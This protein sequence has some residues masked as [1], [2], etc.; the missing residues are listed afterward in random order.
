MAAGTAAS[1]QARPRGAPRY[2]PPG[3]AGWLPPILLGLLALWLTV[4]L[5]KNPQQFVSVFLT[6]VTVGA[7]YALVALGLHAGL[8]HHRAHQLRPRRRVHVGRDDQ[9]SRSPSAG[10]AST[11]RS[12]ASCTLGRIVVVDALRRDGVLRHLNVDDRAPRLQAAAQRAAARTADHGDRRLVHPAST[13][14]RRSTASTTAASGRS[15]RRRRSS[16][17]AAFAYRWK[18]L[19]VVLITVP[20]LLALVYLVKRTRPGKAMRATAQDMEAARML[21]INVDRTIAFTFALGGRARGRRRHALHLLLHAGALRRRLPARPVRV[22]RRRARRHRQPRRRRARR[23]PDRAHR[24]TSTRG[25]RYGARREP[26]GR[27]RSSS[28]S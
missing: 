26:T 24:R 23:D 3:P 2:Q 8:R 9:R 1:A 21:G 5:V 27:S 25:C 6:G 17:S 28:R 10:W 14:R 7:I 12:P 16:R 20:V 22:H 4:N 15:S 19:I 18:S 11:A 13:S